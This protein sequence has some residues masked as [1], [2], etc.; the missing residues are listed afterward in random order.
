M[1]R[2]LTIAVCALACAVGPLAATS[3]AARA[4]VANPCALVPAAAVESALHIHAAPTAIASTTPGAATCNYNRGKLTIEIGLTAYKN[5][6]PAAKQITIASLPNGQY[7]TYAHTTQTQLVFVEG[8]TATGIYVVIRQFV[9]IP[10]AKLVKLGSL[11][12]KLLATSS[13]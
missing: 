12:N 4:G 8:S 1:N 9:R 6:A 11:V 5:L 3:A 2:S 10:Q 13:P 7:S